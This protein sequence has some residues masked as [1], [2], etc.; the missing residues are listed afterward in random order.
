VL[1]VPWFLPAV[2]S[3]AVILQMFLLASVGGLLL[4]AAFIRERDIQ[5]VNPMVA[6][7]GEQHR[8]RAIE[9]GR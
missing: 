3:G 7:A 9:N 5:Q 2:S 6:N 1:V 4:M 8:K